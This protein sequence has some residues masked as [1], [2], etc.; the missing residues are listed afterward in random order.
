M[1][2][3]LLA[4][5][6]A[7]AACA[8]RAGSVT[9]LHDGPPEPPALRAALTSLAAA[10]ERGDRAAFIAM[11]CPADRAEAQDLA[12]QILSSPKRP[13]HD[14]RLEVATLA[15][16]GAAWRGTI[17]LLARIPPP[18]R[19]GPALPPPPAGFARGEAGTAATTLA[20]TATPVPGSDAVQLSLRSGVAAAVT[21]AEIEVSLDAKP[22]RARSRAKLAFE[23]APRVALLEVGADAAV[24][25]AA[26]GAT[27]TPVE[28]TL[29]S[30]A[31]SAVRVFWP[32]GAARGSLDVEA[33]V[34]LPADALADGIIALAHQAQ[35]VPFATGGHFR[36]DLVLDVPLPNRSV[37]VGTPED[38]PA[39]E[40]RRRTRW[41]CDRAVDYLPLAAGPYEIATLQDGDA[42]LELWRTRDV[43]GDP[44]AILTELKDLVADQEQRIGPLPYRALRLVE[45]PTLEGLAI[46]YA[47]MIFMTPGLLATRELRVEILS[48]EVGHQWWGNAVSP[49]PSARWSSEGMADAMKDLFVRRRFGEARWLDRQDSHRTALLGSL[50]AGSRPLGTSPG[51]GDA[52][53]RGALFV[54]AL[55]AELGNELFDRVLR[56]WYAKL[57]DGEP[58]TP[59]YRR[60]AEVE[61]GRALGDVFEPWLGTTALPVV[62]LETTQAPE[63][64]GARVQLV[65]RQDA[66]AF[67]LNV[68]LRAVGPGGERE[69]WTVRL[70]GLESRSARVLPFVPKRVELDP[71]RLLPR[72][73]DD[74]LPKYLRQEAYACLTRGE[75]ARARALLER[76]AASELAG[77]DTAIALFVAR[78]LDG[79]APAVA[80][81]DL[82][83]ILGELATPE[84]RQAAL[85]AAADRLL[86]QG[87]PAAA[88]PLLQSLDAEVPDGAAIPRRLGLALRALGREDEAQAAFRRALQRRPDDAASRAA[89]GLEP[90][91][92][93]VAT[94]QDIPLSPVKL[95][96]LKALESLLPETARLVALSGERLALLAPAQRLLLTGR[97]AGLAAVP[98]FAPSGA[99]G[100][101]ALDPSAPKPLLAVMEA[102]RLRS[103]LTIV[104]VATDGSARV[105]AQHERA[106]GGAR[107]VLAPGDGSLLAAWL[108]EGGTWQWH[109]FTAP[110]R[111]SSPG[112]DDDD[113]LR[114]IAVKDDARWQAVAVTPEPDGEATG[115]DVAWVADPGCIAVLRQEGRALTCEG[116]EGWPAP[117]GDARRIVAA[118]SVGNGIALLFRTRG[119]GALAE[120]AVVT[121]D[122]LALA[123][124]DVLEARLPKEATDA[125]LAPDGFLVVAS[126][127]PTDDGPKA[128]VLTGHASLSPSR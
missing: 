59:D 16:D 123:G 111:A 97:A 64:P 75:A 89:L 1:H 106:P 62:S 119:G 18:R 120:D 116:G 4:L 3:V 7:G 55:R 81:R 8:A 82:D 50:G 15:P 95:P 107:A 26:G 100:V 90:S 78:S 124:D 83:P 73:H 53:D 61:A 79:V 49:H 113:G 42:R 114:R 125:A 39:P 92:E 69:D 29:E 117:D 57:A 108:G 44:K 11:I 41:T 21:R 77:Q 102:Q 10:C 19:D 67:P 40:G 98:G 80:R 105:I 17:V 47:S 68:P 46:S 85:L 32:D 56:R 38:L 5:A 91:A 27:V 109:R 65:L 101:V 128:C 72:V 70:T 23:P 104:E 36:Y 12:P 13:L 31:F 71:D 48:H 28:R 9:F 84:Q 127:C 33:E 20:F 51:G 103:R 35:A 58:R 99:V 25:A 37:S 52:Y 74:E 76:L 94:P 121:K 88:L 126:T 34:L 63:G 54:H 6:L 110:P 118:H 30:A 45:L 112:P 22:P 93:P 115:P 2:R 24:R 14:V 87:A 86:D 96:A 122:L 60:E 66:P 43:G